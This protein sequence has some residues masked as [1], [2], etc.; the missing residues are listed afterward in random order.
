[1]TA[2]AADVPYHRLARTERQGGLPVLGTLLVLVGAGLIV[3]VMGVLY[4]LGLSP[5]WTQASTNLAL[6]GLILVVFFAAR[7]VQRRPAGS[8]SSVVGRIRWRWLVICSGWAL[9]AVVTGFVVAV[10]V[11]ALSSGSGDAGQAA[12]S[13]LRWVGWLPFLVA[14]GSMLITVPFQ[15]AGEE[16]L[17]RGW[18]VQLF[19]CYLRTPW[20]GIVVGGLLWTLLH[21]PSTP[22]AFAVLML[23][24][25]VLGW[26]VIRTG[27]LEAAI[28]F[29]VVN[30]LWVFLFAAAFA[31][32]DGATNAGAASWQVLLVDGV[33]LPLF[34]W[35]V[36]RSARRSGVTRVGS[37]AV[38]DRPEPAT[39]AA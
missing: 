28:A 31:G 1:M 9:L 26:L 20:V 36:L 37:P 38:V 34:A 22:W 17:A 27:G 10:T 33:T 15:A 18:M 30:N 2:P 7:W 24:S 19:G 8:V 12:D 21:F 13:S 5:V 16:Y 23:W 25:V 14:A 4:A 11:L 35:L 39:S 32:V 29:H 3:V 6:G